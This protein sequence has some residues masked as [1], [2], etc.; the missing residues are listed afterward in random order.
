M[1]RRRFLLAVTSAGVLGVAGC[2]GDGDDGGNGTDDG[3]N[4]SGNGGDGDGNGDGGGNGD[5]DGNGDMETPT[6]TPTENGG[7]NGMENGDDGGNGNGSAG[8]ALGENFTW[9]SS[10]VAEMTVETPEMGEAS[11]TVRFNSG[12]FHQTVESNQGTFDIYRVDGDLYMVQQGETCIKNPGQMPATESGVD[13][14]NQ[15]SVAEN[16]PDLTPEGRET[17][18][19]EEM[20]VYE[21]QSDGQTMTWYVSVESGYL[22]RVEFDQGTVDY[23]SWGEVGPIEKPDM[24]CQEVGG[25]DGGGGGGGDGYGG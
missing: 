12:D 6:E 11:T 19:G 8:P 9:E 22:R 16:Y 17:I 15:D 2:I 21:A 24:E 20:Y 5:G 10:F 23:H 14:G 13:P 3:G 25:G 4:G 7:D 1:E 18:D